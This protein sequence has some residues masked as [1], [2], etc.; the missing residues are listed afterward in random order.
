MSA[1]GAKGRHT[2]APSGVRAISTCVS[3]A[4]RTIT[5]PVMRWAWGRRHLLDLDAQVVARPDHR[6]WPD[7]DAVARQTQSILPAVG[8]RPA[9]AA[10]VGDDVQVAAMRWRGFL[11]PRAS[12]TQGEKT[13][14]MEKPM[15][16]DPRSAIV[17]IPST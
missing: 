8:H 4:G 2:W 9:P 17:L 5:S 1:L 10:A 6:G 11:A 16:E 15:I 13:D 7:L 12:D 3:A 14:P